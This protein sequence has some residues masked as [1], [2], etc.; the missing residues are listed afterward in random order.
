[1]KKLSL[2]VAAAMVT[3]MFSAAVSAETINT[4]GM[5]AEGL[6]TYSYDFE[7]N[8]ANGTYTNNTNGITWYRPSGAE[9]KFIIRGNNS[10][11]LEMQQTTAGKYPFIRVNLLKTDAAPLI[12]SLADAKSYKVKFRMRF[13][14]TTANKT[15]YMYL[16]GFWKFTAYTSTYSIQCNNGAVAAVSGAKTSYSYKNDTSDTTI[17]KFHNYEIDV[18][19]ANKTAA[20]KIDGNTIFENVPQFVNSKGEVTSFDELLLAYQGITGNTAID[21]IE[22]IVT[23]NSV[24]GNENWGNDTNIDFEDFTVGKIPA[25]ET[26]NVGGFVNDKV[27][28][29]DSFFSF[30][31]YSYNS[32]NPEQ[33]NK[34]LTVTKTATGSTMSVK[35]DISEAVANYSEYEIS[36]KVKNELNTASSSALIKD[37]DGSR[38]AGGTVV[39]LTK[40]GT[41]SY[42]DY[43]T[44]TGAETKLDTTVFP[45]AVFTPGEWV[46][47]K[48][49]VNKNTN[50]SDIY[51]GDME[52]PV[53]EGVTANYKYDG[54][55]FVNSPQ[56]S[57]TGSISLDDIVITPI[58]EDD[59]VFTYTAGSADKSKFTDGKVTA[60]CK[61]SENVKKNPLVLIGEFNAAGELVNIAASSTAEAGIITANLSGVTAAEGRSVKIMLW[62]G[63]SMNP[64][65]RSI[66]LSPQIPE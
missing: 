31:N 59:Y 54:G 7:K 9:T 18:D 1:M 61:I 66:T 42:F 3:G 10:K 38:A 29:T 16:G 44:G 63:E 40:S 57:A 53:A 12:N 14:P 20:L 62:D 2:I 47:V 21:D 24:C 11:Y 25:S 6:T 65:K 13:I 43:S 48:F 50:K 33:I 41:A 64:I 27:N 22:V 36:F 35:R 30:I 60:E 15:M 4:N 32:E 37:G 17:N 49:R 19:K 56:N 46:D 28:N 8:T 5:S 51:I 39:K 26:E 55:T 58:K 23:D 34:F 52:T 45:K